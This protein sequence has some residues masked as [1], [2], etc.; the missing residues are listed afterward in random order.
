[1]GVTQTIDR[2]RWSALWHARRMPARAVERGL[3]PRL[4]GD[5]YRPHETLSEH[6][7][8]DPRARIETIHPQ[9]ALDNPL[10]R[11]I[12]RRDDLPRDGAL[13][14][15]SMFD[16]PKRH[17][18]A[19]LLAEVHDCRI[20]FF[21]DDRRGEFHPA[22]VT[23]DGHDLRLRE[24]RWRPPHRAQTRP[25]RTARR[26]ERAT[27]I[28][29]RVY[30]NH[31]HWLSAHLPKLVL[32]QERGLLG[33][34]VLPKTR[35]RV[36]D[37][38]LAALGIDPDAC[39]TCDPD[40]P[41]DVGTLTLLSTDRF[42]P[43]LLRPVRDRLAPPDPEAADA[44]VFISRKAS[45]GRHLLSEDALRPL[46]EARGFTL[47]KMEDLGFAEQVA[48]MRRTRVLV[49]PH[50]AGLTNMMFCPP[51]AQIVEIGDPGFPNPNFYA[52]ACAMGLG[53]RIVAGTSV[54]EAP[55]PLERDLTIAP[56][57]L[58]PAI[59]AAIRDAETS[60]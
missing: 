49:A 38:S 29:E 37:A 12:E 17:A 45:R 3:P 13:W 46:L 23:A 28:A 36:M 59:D 6:A 31:S 22:I 56:D 48:L 16:V 47:V 39:I 8:R 2:L 9:T 25:G 53:Y 27:W 18:A 41:L 43:E 40:E 21:A 19:T 30:D 10:P 7:A 4:L 52:L 14:G 26:L 60:R 44:R 34:L 54:G 57:D 5:R 15:Y 58:L 32:L 11:N 55:H 1:M 50:G 24:I 33:D 20:A 35:T 51:G 42:R